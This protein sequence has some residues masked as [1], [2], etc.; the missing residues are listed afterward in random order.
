MKSQ[1]NQ[2]SSKQKRATEGKTRNQKLVEQL[3]YTKQMKS[4]TNYS[5]HKQ[6]Y[7]HMTGDDDFC[8]NY[9]ILNPGY[10]GFPRDTDDK[11]TNY[12]A[13]TK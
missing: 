11:W 12:L 9:A 5:F 13:T 10:C 4:I 8:R 3:K 6:K 1:N 2:K 7:K